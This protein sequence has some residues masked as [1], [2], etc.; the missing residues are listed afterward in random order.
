[1]SGRE[2]VNKWGERWDVLGE[3]GEKVGRERERR[4]RVVSEWG[5]RDRKGECEWG[6]REREWDKRERG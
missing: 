2:R 1:M 3:R 5:E 6:N 4:Q